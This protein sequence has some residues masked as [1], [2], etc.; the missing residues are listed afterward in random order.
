VLYTR[1]GCH[2]CEEAKAVLAR[3]EHSTGVGFVEVDIA[4]DP[5]LTAEYGDRIPVVVLDGREHGYWRVDE[6]RLRRDIA[7]VRRRLD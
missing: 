3:V 6:A 4:G 5:G 1:S 7:S 2:L